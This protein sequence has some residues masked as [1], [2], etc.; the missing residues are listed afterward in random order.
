MRLPGSWGYRRRHIRLF[1]HNVNSQFFIGLMM[2]LGFGHGR[3]EN[4]HYDEIDI[5]F[6]HRGYSH[7]VITRLAITSTLGY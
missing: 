6:S 2:S 5:G 1:S 3:T 7:I 4:N